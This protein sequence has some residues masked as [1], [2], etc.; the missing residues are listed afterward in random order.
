MCQES[1]A[2]LTLH[3]NEFERNVSELSARF[4]SF[5]TRV[6]DSNV[7]IDKLDYPDPVERVNTFHQ[8]RVGIFLLRSVVTRESIAALVVLTKV[9]CT[10]RG[11]LCLLLVFFRF[12]CRNANAAQQHRLVHLLCISPTL[13]FKLSWLVEGVKV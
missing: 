4:C 3:A 7:Q 12:P 1:N 2:N 13:A 9:T 5:R 6:L 8:T 10:T 11:D